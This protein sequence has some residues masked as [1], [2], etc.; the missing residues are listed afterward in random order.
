MEHAAAPIRIEQWVVDG[1]VVYR[2]VGILWGGAEPTD[3]LA[4]RFKAGEPY[5]RVDACAKP[6]STTTWS[7]WWHAWRPPAAGRY[8]IVLKI[9]D[10]RFPT[11]RLDVY[12]YARS[13]D[14]DQ[15]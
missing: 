11:K 12:Y 4:I 1:R 3:A 2:V 6:A 14:I 9:D 15:I 7:L 13:V 8:D 5:V 10:P